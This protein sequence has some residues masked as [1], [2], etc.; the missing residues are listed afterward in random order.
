MT[1]PALRAL[2]TVF[3]GRLTLAC[4]PSAQ[5]IFFSDLLLRSVVE[6][7]TVRPEGGAA[8]EKMWPISHFQTV[9]SAFLETHQDFFGFS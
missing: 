9:L 4:V 1:L 3:S 2:A 7:H 8:A 5:E 6:L